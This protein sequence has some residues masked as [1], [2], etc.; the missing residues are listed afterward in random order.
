[1]KG[2]V[3]VNADDPLLARILERKLPQRVIS[4]GVDKKAEVRASSIKASARGMAFN[5]GKEAVRLKTPV[6]GNVYNALAVIAC[7]RSLHVPAE[8]IRRGLSRFA[9]PKGRQVFHWIGRTTV[10]DDTYNANPVSFKNAVRT[11]A[12][13]KGRGRAV[14]VGADMLELGGRAEGLHREVG[15]FAAREG[16]D[17]LLTCGKLAAH[18][19]AGAKSAG[20]AM[21]IRSFKDKET[22]LTALCA[23]LLPG[24]VVLVKGSRGMRMEAVVEGLIKDQRKA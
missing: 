5:V 8:G 14:L 4:Y 24:D 19:A 22:L 13:M 9:P 6:W 23:L 3:I 12:V 21:E 11:L 15:V 20:H 17:I 7:A 16:V 1:L 18:I 2:V 10:I